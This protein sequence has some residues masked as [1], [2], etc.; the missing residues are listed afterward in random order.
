MLNARRR[1]DGETVSAYFERKGNGPFACLICNEEVVLRSGRDRIDH[2]AHANPFACEYAQGESDL[3][4]KCKRKIYE[5]LCKEP[6]V[7]NVFMEL[8]LGTVRPDVSATIK[9]TPVAIEVQISSLSIETIL[10][11]TI[12]YHQRGIYVLWLLPWTKELDMERYAPALWEKWI[13]AC[14]FGRVYYWLEGLD[15]AEY[16]FEPFLRIIPR[17]R[18]QTASGRKM[19]A[20]GYVQ[21]SGRFRTPV[22]GETLNIARDFGPRKRCWWEGGGVKVPDGK[23][24]I[25]K[26]RHGPTRL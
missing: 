11:R 3:H 19:T 14:Y 25:R 17:T 12:D 22:R 15:V 1:S 7:E 2:F 24:F 4:R 13:H 21:R 6:G 16:R 10:R 9:G 26:E 20:G 5:A 23:I 18:W 8:P